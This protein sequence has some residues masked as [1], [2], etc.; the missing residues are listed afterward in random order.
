MTFTETAVA[1]ARAPAGA[2]REIWDPGLP[3]FGLRVSGS[4]H[5]TWQLMYRFGGRKRRLMLGSYPALSLEMARDAAAAALDSVVRGR[6][7][8]AERAQR[9]GGALTF[10]ALARAYLERYAKARKASWRADA[11]MI[12]RDLLPAWR[13]RPAE[14]ITRRDAIELLDQVV[15]RG[16]PI[17]ANR[18]LALLR[19][20][21]DWGVERDMVPANP[22]AGVRPPAAERRRE[23]V[24]S[25]PEI[26][27]L[28]RACGAMGW[29]FGPLFRL[30]LLTAQ[31]RGALARLSLRD[32]GLNSRVW[33]VPPPDRP[34]GRPAGP[35]PEVPLSA[36]AV[37]ILAA[38]PRPESPYVFPARG[39]P[40]RPVSGFSAA[41]TRARRLSGIGDLRADDL[42]RTAAAAMTRLGAPLPA[43][44][45]ILG[46]RTATVALWPID[47]SRLLEDKRQALEA[48]GDE[49]RAI[50]ER[51]G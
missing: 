39:H 38:L 48:W 41:V 42:R 27:A 40:E 10:E 29:P 14:S 21:Y 13:R 8:A 19:K 20:I 23:R 3:G 22:V 28:W 36:F 16:H 45:D 26:A 49:L 4:G 37:E 34:A 5:K 1:E 51:S 33:R 2:R 11:G 9:T 17:A 18:R 7:P 47:P 24:L 25:E 50:V 46:R 15:A 43:V 30:M 12:E 35:G 31:R 44:A 6:D 32:V